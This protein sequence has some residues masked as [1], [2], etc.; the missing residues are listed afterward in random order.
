MLSTGMAPVN[1]FPEWLHGFVQYQPVS[2][3][4]ETLRSLAAG[5]LAA[6]N[7]MTS[8][9]WCIGLVVA[10]G[11]IAVRMQRRVR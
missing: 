2:Q 6:S 3:V 4:T 7:L 5:N 8:L 9:A 11:A 1:S 10:F